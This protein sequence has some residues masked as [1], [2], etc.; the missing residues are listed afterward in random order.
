MTNI[1]TSTTTNFVE[2]VL[3]YGP[4]PPL[5]WGP[6]CSL[7][8]SESCLF[9]YWFVHCDGQNMLQTFATTGNEAMRGCVQCLPLL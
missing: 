4:M 8:A 5:Q 1:L 2:D 6:I 3:C 9:Q 7:V